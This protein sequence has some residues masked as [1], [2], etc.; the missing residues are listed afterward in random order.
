MRFLVLGAGGL[1]GYFGG[2]LLQG[3]ADVS[4][5][6]RPR[7]A[8]QLAERGLVIKEPADEVAIPVRT[9]AA[10]AVD[11][12]YDIVFLTCKAYDLDSA[13]EAIAPAVGPRSA[14]LPVLNGVNHID[15]LAERFGAEHVLGGMILVRA[16]LAPNGDIIRPPGLGGHEDLAFGELTGAR[17]ARCAAILDALAA[18]GLPGRISN[19]ILVEMWDKFCGFCCNA[20]VSTL[21][22]AWAG[23]IA[24]A[25][26]G[27]GFVKATFDECAR[28][29]AA[30]GYPP[31]NSLRDLCVGM[32]SQPGLG[33]RPS[34]ATDLEEDRKSTRLNS[35]HIQKS[36]MPSS[37]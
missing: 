36:R 18:A 35:S 21:T 32:Y 6:V 23:E 37:A 27:A 7:R 1:G 5:L 14:I 9:V 4:F 2:K 26:A 8:A 20:S 12:P 31:S 22:R 10:G 17:S 19:N 25:P 16:E 30:E 24:M 13:T 29:T 34:I 11:G 15:R 3:G 28:A 33:Y